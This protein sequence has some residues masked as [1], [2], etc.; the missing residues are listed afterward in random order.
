MAVM[1]TTA[2]INTGVESTLNNINNN[3]DDNNDPGLAVGT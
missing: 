3:N 2:G 1:P